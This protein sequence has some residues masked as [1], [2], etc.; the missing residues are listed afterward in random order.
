MS[1]MKFRF[2]LIWLFVLT[3][4]VAIATSFY[5]RRQSQ[6]DAE[7]RSL[8]GTWD[9]VFLE[10]FDYFNTSF[11]FANPRFKLLRPG[12]FEVELLT[13]EV[14]Y[15]VYER[16]GNLL[17]YNQSDPWCA[18]PKDIDDLRPAVSWNAPPSA[19]HLYTEDQRV[20][21]YLF[22]LQQNHDD[23]ESAT[24]FVDPHTEFDWSASW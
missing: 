19:V 20:T 18:C 22:R 15:G 12:L 17:Y 13:G 5:T 23:S 14:V 6:L 24:L 8:E 21:R 2:H 11:D 4:V 16:D 3:A 1:A 7:L 9:A 10:G